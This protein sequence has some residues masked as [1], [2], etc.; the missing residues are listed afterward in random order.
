MK[1]FIVILIYLLPFHLYSQNCEVDTFIANHY[2]TDAK[3]L[4]IQEIQNNPAHPFRDSIQIPEQLVNTY[5]KKLS[6]IYRYENVQVVDSLFVLYHIHTHEAYINNIISLEVNESL[7]WIQY[8]IQDS[9][10]SGNQH[11]DSILNLGSFKLFGTMDLPDHFYI[12]LRTDSILNLDLVITLFEAIEG[13]YLAEASTD[14]FLDP[15]D[16]MDDYEY[17]EIKLSNLN[18]D[19]LIIF[20]KDMNACPEDCFLRHFWVFS[21]INTCEAVFQKSVCGMGL[22]SMKDDLYEYTVAYPNPFINEIFI[23][24]YKKVK[25]ISIYSI[26]GQQVFE[27]QTIDQVLYLS[28]LLSGVYIMAIQY[29]DKIIYQKVLKTFE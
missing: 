25:T 24:D 23:K 21:F 13:V 12:F 27:T 8:L 20:K 14:G 18:G 15:I 6:G 5:L 9:T 17:N 22:S 7:D 1:K 3:M 29:N 19:T 11:M 2:Q 10:A 26:T 16:C 28:K 4:G